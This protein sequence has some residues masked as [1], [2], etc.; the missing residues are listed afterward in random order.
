MAAVTAVLHAFVLYIAANERADTSSQ[1]ARFLLLC[2][3]C[4][5]R[6]QLSAGFLSDL[7]AV[8]HPSH[9]SLILNLHGGG[10]G[11]PS[12][13]RLLTNFKKC[14]KP[15]QPQTEPSPPTCTLDLLHFEALKFG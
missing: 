10:A 14:E 13:N 15:L 4:Q 7:D 1:G 2:L 5:H 9:G 11:V 3:S 12:L 6:K 8:L